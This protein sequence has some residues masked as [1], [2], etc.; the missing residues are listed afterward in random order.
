MIRVVGTVWLLLA[1]GLAA[2]A[3]GAPARA[4]V[5]LPALQEPGMA[6]EMIYVNFDQVDI[7]VMLKTIGDITGINFVVDSVSG[8]ITV[9]SPS[10]IRLGDIYGVME[11]VLQVKGYA[12]VPAGTGGLVKIIPRAD[13]VRHNLEVRIS[14][15]P[16]EIPVNDSVVTQI[17]PL[18]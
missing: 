6:D 18:K 10:K 9:M 2:S 4:P 13:A 17:M 7:R 15:D 14:A 16:A 8:A 1:A 3:E 12:A 11:S 5:P